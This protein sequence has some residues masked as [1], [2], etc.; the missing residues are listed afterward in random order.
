MA[1]A[2][3]LFS[4]AMLGWLLLPAASWCA[5]TP[6]PPATPW[7]ELREQT[8]D[9]VWQ[10]VNDA[11][12]DPTFGGVDWEE[13][14]DTYRAR[15]A[16]AKDREELNALLREMLGKL[17]RTHF[18]ILPR[19]A[20]VFTPKERDRIGTLGADF[21]YSDNKVVVAQVK[22]GSPAAKAHLKPG[23]VISKVDG[24]DLGA[25]SKELAK[26]DMPESRRK[27]YLVNYVNSHAQA[28]VG[29]EVKLATES[30]AGQEQEHDVVS[31]PHD[32]AWS[33]PLGEFPSFPISFTAEHRP[34]HIGYLAFNIFTTEF[35]KKARKF[36]H[37]LQPGDGLV[38]DL[39]GNPGGNA[40][41]ASAICGWLSEKE[42]S[43]GIMHLREGQLSFDVSPQDGAFT[44]PI[45]VLIDA[46]SASTSEIFAAGLQEAKRARIF[47]A[48][49]AGAALPSM[50][51]TLPTG[52]LFQYAIADVTTPAGKLLEGTGV[53]PDEKISRT[54]ADLAAG[55]DPVYAA[56]RA[57][58]DRE[59]AGQPASPATSP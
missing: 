16:D 18:A 26:A 59:R 51:K 22:P 52:D 41:L 19:D 46:T 48:A 1:R 42:F 32:G 29:T 28:A 23:D 20:A 25:L 6:A 47:G 5:D 34:D 13:V 3:R 44:G 43:L 15:L 37:E 53:V 9:E 36:L 57:W 38:I 58:I 7:P 56:A 27:F 45:A 24:M 2:V 30:T 33:E 35:I 4:I 21:T 14:G 54:P 12:F 40:I 49:S 11:Y 31:K 55:T 39:R 17:H 10:T 8:F 50:F